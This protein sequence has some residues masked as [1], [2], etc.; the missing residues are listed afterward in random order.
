ME[1]LS[2]GSERDESSSFFFQVSVSWVRNRDLQTIMLESPSLITNHKQSRNSHEQ[3]CLCKGIDNIVF[4]LQMSHV[5]INRHITG[6]TTEH[7]HTGLDWSTLT[8]VNGSFHLKLHAL[9]C[10]LPPLI[11]TSSL[12]K[13]R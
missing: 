1:K 12:R 7:G 2:N 13:Y 5:Q 3:R 10:F 4:V 9:S 8:E 11:H 6:R